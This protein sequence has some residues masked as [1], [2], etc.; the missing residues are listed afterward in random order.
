[1]INYYP[2]ELQQT[3]VTVQVICAT[4][5]KII[6]YTQPSVSV[7]ELAVKAT[8]IYCM[9][10]WDCTVWKKLATGG[11]VTRVLQDITAQ[12]KGD[13]RRRTCDWAQTQDLR[14]V[15][16]HSLMN[17]HTLHGIRHQLVQQCWNWQTCTCVLGSVT[18]PSSHVRSTDADPLD[19]PHTVGSTECA[20]MQREGWREAPH[21]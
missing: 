8:I 21:Q 17:M 6:Q 11:N 12:G 2:M 16:T 15:Q 13:G 4:Y 5:N 14:S 20:L 10:R 3:C 9:H 18:K 1:M 19:D 7:W